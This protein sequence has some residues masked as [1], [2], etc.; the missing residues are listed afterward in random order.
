MKQFLPDVRPHLVKKQKNKQTK[1]L[2]H[3]V[4]YSHKLLNW[5]SWDPDLKKMCLLAFVQV[6]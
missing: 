2:T 3:L 1:K 6:I 5:S 4:L